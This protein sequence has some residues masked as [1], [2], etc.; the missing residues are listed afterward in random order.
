MA[1]SK[2]NANA[3]V[4]MNFLYRIVEVFE[5]YFNELVE[6]SIRDNFVITYELLDEMMDFGY[7]QSTEPKVLK[8]SER[9]A[10][11]RR[12]GARS[13]A[14]NVAT[15]RTEQCPSYLTSLHCVRVF[16]VSLS[17]VHLRGGA[18]QIRCEASRGCDE[19][20]VLAR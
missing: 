6:E 9:A 18:S 2:R 20:G 19:C 17:Q 14:A 7:P 16:V 13:G 11:T 5:D 15:G 3:M 1:M 12:S 4:I 10:A 8:E